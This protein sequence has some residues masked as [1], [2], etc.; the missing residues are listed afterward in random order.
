MKVL[1]LIV[2]AVVLGAT[3]PALSQEK[4]EAADEL[5][6]VLI[7][8]NPSCA[9]CSLWVK[10]MEAYG[11]E[12][13]TYTT[14][15]ANELKDNLGVPKDMRSCHVAQVGGYIVEGHV[16]ADLIEKMLREKPDIA[17]LTVPGMVTGSPGMEGHGPQDYDVL[18]FTKDGKTS[19]YAHREG[20]AT[21]SD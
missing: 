20:K 18:A 5:P 14:R 2:T 16:P 6:S 8:K 17:G 15:R 12:T 13:K 4:E 7:Y 19:V 21:V 1:T 3:S 11:F 10:H 9:C